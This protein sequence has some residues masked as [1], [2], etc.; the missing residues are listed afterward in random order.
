MREDTTSSGYDQ[1]RTDPIPSLGDEPENQPRQA[2]P[3]QAGPVEPL[4][5][6]RSAEAPRPAG[7]PPADP[8]PG[9]PESYVDPEPVPAADSPVPVAGGYGEPDAVPQDT[10]PV[11]DTPVGAPVASGSDRAGED[12]GAVLFGD[13]EVERFRLRW[14]ELQA[15][16]VDDPARAVQ[17]ADQLVDEVLQALTEVFAAHQRELEDQWR[18]GGT[19]QTEELRVALRSYRSFFDRLLNT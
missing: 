6:P 8:E 14:R 18:G 4:G 10:A 7:T 9:I 12:T 11:S 1:P 17:G 15:D 16:F 13:D 5:G 2:V 3:P 19:G